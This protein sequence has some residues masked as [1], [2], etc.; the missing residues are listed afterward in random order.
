MA[1]NLRFYCV[2]GSSSQVWGVFSVKSKDKIVV[3]FLY[4]WFIIIWCDNFYWQQ[5]PLGLNFGA[6][7]FPRI[8][9]W[10][11][12]QFQ[13]MFY[14]KCCKI[15]SQEIQRNENEFRT[16]GDKGAIHSPARKDIQFYY[17]AEFYVILKVTRWF[18]RLGT[19]SISRFLIRNWA[20]S[21]LIPIFL[22]MENRL[23]IFLVEKVTL[24][25]TGD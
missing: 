21:L 12:N 3:H 5:L 23:V 18:H 24:P 20:K 8:C 11:K 25:V 15:I 4:F 22:Q 1:M 14:F 10:N 13:E 2:Q 9:H 6:K 7:H 17:F 16:S 19:V